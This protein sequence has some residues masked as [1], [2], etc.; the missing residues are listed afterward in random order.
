MV[1]KWNSLF[2]SEIM[3]HKDKNVTNARQFKSQTPTIERN[4]LFSLDTRTSVNRHVIGKKKNKLHFFRDSQSFPAGGVGGAVSPQI[5]VLLYN[6]IIIYLYNIGAQNSWFFLGSYITKRKIGH[7]S[8][9]LGNPPSKGPKLVLI[10][11]PCPETTGQLPPV[12]KCLIS[13]TNK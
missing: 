10:T 13:H 7:S 4:Q 3:K 9:R 12:C 5:V 2:N 11:H 8:R 1:T 6:F